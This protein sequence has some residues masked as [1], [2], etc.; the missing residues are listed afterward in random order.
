[1]NKA[2]GCNGEINPTLVASV[3]NSVGNSVAQFAPAFG[4]LT[5]ETGQLARRGVETVREQSI[6]AADSTRGHTR[7]EPI[8][9]VLIAAAVGASLMA[10][11]FLV[12]RGRGARA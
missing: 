8:K 7:D 10:L 6:R 11:L 4:R 2:H 5:A 3:A 9:S 1:M 12:S